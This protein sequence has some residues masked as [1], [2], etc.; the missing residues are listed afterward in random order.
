MGLPSWELLVFIIRK[1]PSRVLEGFLI[2]QPEICL[3]GK[4]Q[5]EHEFSSTSHTEVWKNRFILRFLRGQTRGQSRHNHVTD[6]SF[7]VLKS[8]ASV[9]PFPAPRRWKLFPLLMIFIAIQS[10]SLECLKKGVDKG[11][12]MGQ[13]KPE[14]S[15]PGTE[16]WAGRFQTRGWQE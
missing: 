13:L 2:A 1:N 12:K 15:L 3:A 11:R 4:I 5:E 16:I 8:Y 14:D 7:T 9:K 6:L 10:L